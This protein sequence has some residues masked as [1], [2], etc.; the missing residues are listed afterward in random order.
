M[1]EDM[2]KE[3]FYNKPDKNIHIKEKKKINEKNNLNPRL[4]G[5]IYFNF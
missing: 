3:A 4:W 2:S 5:Y 1:K